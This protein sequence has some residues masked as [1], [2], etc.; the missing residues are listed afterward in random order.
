M[1]IGFRF[2]EV[3]ERAG[4]RAI[5]SEAAQAIGFSDIGSGYG[6]LL[7]TT[8]RCGGCTVQ[9]E[10]GLLNSS[11]LLLNLPAVRHKPVVP[12]TCRSN[13]SYSYVRMDNEILYQQLPAGK[14]EDNNF[15]ASVGSVPLPT[16]IKLFDDQG[17]AIRKTGWTEWEMTNA[18]SELHRESSG[19]GVLLN[20]AV[21]FHTDTINILNGLL[22]R[23]GAAC[24]YE[25]YDAQKNLLLRAAA[26]FHC[27]HSCLTS[28]I[29]SL[30]LRKRSEGL[31]DVNLSIDLVS[32]FLSWS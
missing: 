16:I 9:P 17:W 8:Q 21:A 10:K 27:T 18:W 3:G 26:G 25:F 29:V 5:A 30:L 20:G 23:V 13:K 19:L 4:V 2:H 32:S 31:L 28:S 12:R 1:K 15:Y 22:D 6:R 14:P 24:Q 11:S 7:L